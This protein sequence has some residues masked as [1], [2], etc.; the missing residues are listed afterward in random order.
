MF[1]RGCHHC[2]DFGVVNDW[3]WD[4]MDRFG[5]LTTDGMWFWVFSVW[6]KGRG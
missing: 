4:L 5:S 3:S 2:S 6:G 1:A